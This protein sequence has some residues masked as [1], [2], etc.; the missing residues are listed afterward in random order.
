MIVD[1]LGR[2][3]DYRPHKDKLYMDK[4]VVRLMQNASLKRVFM[5]NFNRTNEFIHDMRNVVDPK[6]KFRE[7]T[8]WS[9]N[10][11]SGSG[12]SLCVLSLIKLILRRR[13]VW[14]L[15]CFTDKQM[16]DLANEF[17]K[18]IFLVRDEDIK[19]TYGE[20]S[21]RTASQLETLIETCRKSGLSA[22]FIQPQELQ[23]G[24]AKWYLETVDMDL[25]NRITRMALKEP[26]T[27]KVVGA[28]YVPV[29]PEDDTDW[30]EYNKLKDLFIDRMREGKIDDTKIDLN[31]CVA[32]VMEHEDYAERRTKGERK[33][34]IQQCFPN[35]TIGEIKTIAVLLEI[36]RRQQQDADAD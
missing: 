6:Y 3:Y 26:Q 33:V 12:K 27:M 22:V 36:R 8:V 18:D 25:N 23:V 35:Y 11:P 17:D 31:A 21:H 9:V 24:V 28:V 15:F 34:L 1:I 14:Q 4:M 10:G 2:R 32:K 29:V 16:L 19:S 30:I 5:P 13:G 20:G 7:N